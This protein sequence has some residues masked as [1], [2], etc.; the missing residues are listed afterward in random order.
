MVRTSSTARVRRRLAPAVLGSALLVLAV[1]RFHAQTGTGVDRW[2][3]SAVVAHRDA[4]LTAAAVAV[5]N[6]GSPAVVAGVAVVIAL[7]LWWRFASVLVPVVLLVTVGAAGVA[8]TLLKLMVG[9]ARPPSGVQLL[10]E[11][12]H[13]FP[14]GHVT[15]TITLLG[16]TA[17]LTAGMLSSMT[18]TLIG[19]VAT[20][21]VLLVA[22]TR[23]YLGVHW[24]TDILGGLLLGGLAIMLGNNVFQRFEC[25]SNRRTSAAPAPDSSA[26]TPSIAT[27]VD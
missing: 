23:L 25:W 27:G 5:T 26:T 15:G 19:A 13:A 10:P 22:A 11:T 6:A 9:A 16:L 21:V 8:S 2:V 7:L 18:R 14:S 4:G 3:L 12:D 1:V 20:I 17:V 24:F